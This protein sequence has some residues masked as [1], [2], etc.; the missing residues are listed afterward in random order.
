MDRICYIETLPAEAQPTQ[1]TRYIHTWISILHDFRVQS[2][3]TMHSAMQST[4]RIKKSLINRRVTQWAGSV[5]RPPI[6]SQHIQRKSCDWLSDMCDGTSQFH[7]NSFYHD[8]NGKRRNWETAEI[9]RRTVT[10]WDGVTPPSHQSHHLDKAGFITSRHTR[11]YSLRF[12][13]SIVS[14]TAANTKRMFS[15][16]A[17][18]STPSKQQSNASSLAGHTAPWLFHLSFSFIAL[19]SSYLCYAEPSA[20]ILHRNVCDCSRQ[21]HRTQLFTSHGAQLS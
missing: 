20:F 4:G 17:T 14:F 13:W 16:S 6:T 9:W 19:R 7:H 2:T 3:D 5:L 8:A 1:D 18:T 15:V 12:S 21:T 11:L 10:P